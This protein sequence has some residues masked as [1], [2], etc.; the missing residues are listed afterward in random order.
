MAQNGEDRD[1]QSEAAKPTQ[2]IRLVLF[3]RHHWLAGLA[4]SKCLRQV[5]RL[6][7]AFTH[8]LPPLLRT[9][10]VQHLVNPQGRWL[11]ALTTDNVAVGLDQ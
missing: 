7:L 4:A 3:I 6:A 1:C 8:N 9:I 11:L 5:I 2:V 10:L